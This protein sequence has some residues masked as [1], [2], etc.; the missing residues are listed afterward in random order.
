MRCF[1]IRERLVTDYRDGELGKREIAQIEE[2]LRGCEACRELFE[3]VTRFA[4]LPRPERGIEMEPDSRVWENI[5]RKIS[6]KRG[7]A[8]EIQGLLDFITMFFKPHPAL[9]TAVAFSL[10]VM[11]GVM[12]YFPIRTSTPIDLEVSEYLSEQIEMMSI[13][14]SGDFERLNSDDDFPIFEADFFDWA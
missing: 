13:L 7:E 14:G 9:K 11:I 12:I 1:K 2:H 10:V 4:T 8:R 5:D 6:R 3:E